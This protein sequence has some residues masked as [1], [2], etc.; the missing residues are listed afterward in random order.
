MQNYIAQV[1]SGGYVGQMPD[2]NDPVFKNRIDQSYNQIISLALV[3]AG[4]LLVVKFIGS[5]SK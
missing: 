5:L 3:V 4:V 2:Y 1:P